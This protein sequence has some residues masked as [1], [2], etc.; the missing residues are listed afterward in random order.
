MSKTTD[1]LKRKT[2]S[3][4]TLKIVGDNRLSVTGAVSPMPSIIFQKMGEA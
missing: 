2:F 3:L 1:V 4:I